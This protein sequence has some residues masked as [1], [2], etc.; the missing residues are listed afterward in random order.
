[1]PSPLQSKWLCWAS[2]IP[3]GSEWESSRYKGVLSQN[4]FSNSISLCVCVSLCRLLTDCSTCSKVFKRER[5]F[6]GK[7]TGCLIHVWLSCVILV[8]RCCGCD[9]VFSLFAWTPKLPGIVDQRGSVQPPSYHPARP[10]LVTFARCKHFIQSIRTWAVRFLEGIKA[11]SANTATL[12]R[13][14]GLGILHPPP[15]S[16]D[17]DI[18]GEV[19]KA[20]HEAKEAK[21]AKPCCQL[22]HL[23]LLLALNL[24]NLDAIMLNHAWSVA[25]KPSWDMRSRICFSLATSDW[26]GPNAYYSCICLVWLLTLQ[27]LKEVKW[28]SLVQSRKIPQRCCLKAHTFPWVPLP[29][30]SAMGVVGSG[31]QNSC[32]NLELLTS[33]HDNGRVAMILRASFPKI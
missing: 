9:I 15:L 18:S 33:S 23:W 1:M 4:D 11:Y 19:G 31:A 16:S 22:L 25:Q 27:T 30:K 13:G 7:G 5:C 6:L 8:C 21:T 20:L 28:H 29:V 17:T 24:E 32:V 12:G 3:S 14:G 2:F 26:Q 10:N